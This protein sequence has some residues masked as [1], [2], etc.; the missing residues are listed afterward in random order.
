MRAATIRQFGGWQEIQVSEVPDPTPGPGE[1][2]VR[3]R[4]AGLNHLDVW[5][6]RGRAPVPFP[7]VLGSDAA[8]IVHSVGAGV[9]SLSPGDEVVLHPGLGCERCEMC[10]GGEV[11]LCEHF[12]IVGAAS[13]GTFAELVKAPAAAWFP[14]PASLSFEE[15][16]ALPVN[17]LTAWRMVVTRAHLRP[18]ET[19][20]VTGIGGGVA[21]AVLQ[22]A[23]ASGARVFVTS[24][25]DE[26]IARAR[27]LGAEAGV[28]YR[29]ES[30]LVHAVLELT[31]HRGVDAVFDS[32]GEATYAASLAV[33]RK[34]GRLVLCGVTTGANPPA[35]LRSLYWKQIAVVGSTLGSRQEMAEILRLAASGHLRAVVDSIYP[36]EQIGQATRRLEE[37]AQFG[38]ILLCI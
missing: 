22:I 17:F 7:H 6:R 18:G 8:G 38:K 26:K 11:S 21:L 33:L 1:V 9:A 16:A 12:G 3:V 10:L 31:Q 4:A 20:L 5:V 24:S 14:K 28:N 29:T 30:D 34:G 36:L 2:V 35:D 13:W 23:R 19:V 25:S 37:G 32:A 15:A 27:E